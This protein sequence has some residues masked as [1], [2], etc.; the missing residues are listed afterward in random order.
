M[1]KDSLNMAVR[2][3]FRVEGNDGFEIPDLLGTSQQHVDE[4]QGDDRF[5]AV[6]LS[7]RDIN[8]FCQFVNILGESKVKLQESG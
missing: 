3:F 6:R 4:A 1:S 5:A 8:A 7:R 2:V